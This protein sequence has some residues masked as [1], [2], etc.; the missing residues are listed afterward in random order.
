M[1]SILITSYKEPKTIGNTLKSIVQQKIGEKYEL[2]ISAPDNETL[3]VV[4]K[5]AKKDKRIKIFKDKGKGKSTAINQILPKLKGGIIILTD[6]DVYLGKNSLNELLIQFKDTTIGAVSGQPVSQNS[7]NNIFGFWSH[8]LLYAAHKLREKR[9]KK[10]KFL[11]CSGYLW[12]F[13][14]IIKSFPIDVAEDSIVPALLWQKGWKIAYAE[15]ALVYVKYPNNLKDTIE[16]RRR[17]MQAHEKLLNYAQF[18]KMK[19]LKNEIINSFV[20]FSYPKSLKEY[21]YLFFLFPFRFYLWL[22]AYYKK[23]TKRNYSDNWKR[24]ESTK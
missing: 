2:W 8:L 1:I 14:N 17:S 16:Q 23:Y 9:Y 18:P 7:R 11:E 21:F 12:A 3:D 15:K 4:R 6:G 24:V 10:G 22:L 20:L 13:R 19:S 5:Y